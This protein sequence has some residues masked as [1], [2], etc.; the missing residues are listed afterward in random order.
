MLQIKKAFRP[1]KRDEKPLTSRGATQ[2]ELRLC[3]SLSA[4]VLAPM[5]SGYNAPPAAGSTRFCFRPAAPGCSSSGNPRRASTLPGSLWLP[6]QNTL[7]IIAIDVVIFFYYIPK[8][9]NV[10]NFYRIFASKDRFSHRFWLVSGGIDHQLFPPFP[11]TEP[12][13]EY[14]R[15]DTFIQGHG[16]PDA[17]QTVS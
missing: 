3:S 15:S 7:P 6:F 9:R 13:Q 1:R 11:G 8:I 4:Q 16:N 2:F 14:H 5:P 12:D 17:H 10:K